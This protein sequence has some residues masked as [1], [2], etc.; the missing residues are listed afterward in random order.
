MRTDMISRHRP[1]LSRGSA[2]HDDAGGLLT[3]RSNALTPPSQ[4]GRPSGYVGLALPGH[5]GED[6]VG[7]APTSRFC[8]TVA[9]VTADHQA[10]QRVVARS[11]LTG[12][13]QG[14]L[15][16]IPATGKSID[17]PLIDI[18]RFG[19]D[20]LAHEHWGVVDMLAM[21]QQLGVVPDGPPA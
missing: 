19:D 1:S 13:R 15:M 14:E 2:L 16:G 4:A 9:S 20:G 21:M 11:K 12:T 17:V 18:I 3:P 5:S 8:I 10:V 7:L 6:R